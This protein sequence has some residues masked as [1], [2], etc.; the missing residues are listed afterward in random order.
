[1]LSHQTILMSLSS[2]N[3]CKKE[4]YLCQNMT[5]H[6]EGVLRK[7][8]I[9]I[10][11]TGYVSMG[12]VDIYER[13]EPAMADGHISILRVKSEYDPYFIV[14]YLRSYFGQVQFDKWWS[15]SSGQIHVYE[16]DL[17]EFLIPESS[18]EGIPLEKQK[19]IAQKITEKLNDV[20]ELEKKAKE[21]WEEGKRLF[22]KMILDCAEDERSA[23]QHTLT[24]FAGY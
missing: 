8:D 1:M 4:E 11:S 14:Y 15:G 5:N 12:K 10:A 16:Q 2:Q 21:K 17:G 19:G 23:K 9:L 18:E 7:G 3:P 24:S 6:P 20:F 22:E 13:E